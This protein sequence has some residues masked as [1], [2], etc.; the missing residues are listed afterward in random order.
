MSY[1]VHEIVL[2]YSYACGSYCPLPSEKHHF[3]FK[4]MQPFWVSVVAMMQIET[5]PF[6]MLQNLCTYLQLHERDLFSKST[7]KLKEI[8][9]RTLKQGG[10]KTGT[11][12]LH[13]QPEIQ[14]LVQHGSSCPKP[15]PTCTF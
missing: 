5:W 4:M 15:N 11:R 3:A 7:T 9:T 2:A 13:W 1:A 8:L 6:W 10:A 14:Y 12:S